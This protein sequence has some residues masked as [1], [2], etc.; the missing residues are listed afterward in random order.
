[1]QFIP[2]YILLALL[3]SGCTSGRNPDGKGNLNGELI[4]FHAGSLTVPVDELASA[5]QE[6][7]PRVTINAEA[8]GSRT[9]ARKVSELNRE[10]D[11][12]MSADFQ[13]IESLLIPEF[14]TWNILFARNSMVI[15]FTEKAKYA[16]EITSDNW[17]QI[18]VLGIYPILRN[19]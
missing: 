6:L 12:V 11:L 7:N 18:L 15:T 17:Y 14:A 8:A 9:T 4:I 13:V 10:T 1:M 5:F 3:L 19:S 2:I 16:D